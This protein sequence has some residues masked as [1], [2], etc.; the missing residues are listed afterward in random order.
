MEE[1][2]RE[3]PGDAPAVRRVLEG[4]FPTAAEADL[5]EQLRENGKAVI[6]LVAE[7]E[8]EIVGHVVFTPLTIEPLAG[9]VGLGLGPLAVLPDHEKHGVG[10]RLVQNGL[11]ECRR[12]GAGF[13]SVLGDPDY[14]GRFGFESAREH[15]LRNEFSADDHF[16]VFELRNHGLPPR[17]SMIRYAPEF[18]G[19]AKPLG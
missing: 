2:R 10:R 3:R 7:D 19:M 18:Q 14:Y 12:W 17:D 11:A 15:G 1:I 13:V 9:T 4:A 16:M 8:G 5:A 6:A